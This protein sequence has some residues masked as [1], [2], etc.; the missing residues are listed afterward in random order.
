VQALPVDAVLPELLA[1]LAEAS[2]C[3][4]VAPTGSGKT[5]RVPPALRDGG[6][7]AVVVLEPRRLAARAAARRIASERGGRVGEEVGYQ[8]RFD[9]RVGPRTRL[10]VVTEGVLLRRL[11][12]DPFLEGVGALVFDEFH[13]RHLEGDLGLAMARRVQAAGRGDL[14]LVVLSATLD[15]HAVARSLGGCPVVES[16]GRSFPVTVEHLAADPREDAEQHLARGARRALDAT[17]GDVLC[18]L[19]GVGE[20]KR[21]AR[22]LAGEARRAGAQLLELHGALP[23]AEQDAVLGLR[24][25]RKL[26]LS[27][28]VAESSV[29]VPGVTAV[30]DTGLVRSLRH[31]ARTGLDRLELGRAS[32]ASAEQRRG[33]AGRT[34]PG[35][36]VRLWSAAEERDLAPRDEPEIRRLD[37]AGPVLQLLAWGERDL[38]AFPWYEPP[39]REALARADELLALIGAVDAR[40]LTPVGKRIAALPVHPRIGRLLVEAH[41]LGWPEDG[42]LVAAL[43]SERDPFGRPERQPDAAPSDVLERLHALRAFERRGATGDGPAPLR[44][45]PARAVLAARDQ[46]ARIVRDALGRAP[47]ACDPHLDPLGRALYAAFRDRLAR[48][49]APGSD[50]ALMV[51]GKG[52]RLARESAVTEEEL[53]VCVDLDGAGPEPL[54]RLASGVEREWVDGGATREALE[55]AFDGERLRVVGRKRVNLGPLLLSESDHPLHDAAAGERLLAERAAADLTRALPL[56]D[57]DVMDFL[58]RVRSLRAW[59]PDLGLPAFDDAELAALLPA[60]VVGRRS[61][62][63]LKEAPLLDH[64]R[65]ALSRDQA[66]ALQRDAPARLEVPSGSHVRLVYEPGRPPVLAARIQELFGLEASPTVAGGRVRVLLHLLAPNG[67]P[68][69]VTDDLASFWDG[70]YALVRKELKP[71][72]PKHDWPEDPRQGVARRRPRPRR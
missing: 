53:F 59:R 57:R 67:R 9:H 48:R 69:Q 58:A 26:V 7:G 21:A 37:L 71:R 30:V 60:L 24:D 28:N 22:A 4:L 8:V 32:L 49:R 12:D 56:D 55:P 50:R 33:R 38:A 66:R 14:K 70:T 72:Y 61:F 20:I 19:P 18:F 34:A 46:L 42:A 16:A 40:G 52:V 63:E 51:G 27:T 2:A 41:G 11:Q 62:A 1:A 29:T 15:A 43:L 3:V 45:G 36:C 39:P 35:L 23:A 68:Q 25:G 44:P 10:T 6:F 13:E 5:T 47:A 31:D 65:G 17:P 54:V 64:L